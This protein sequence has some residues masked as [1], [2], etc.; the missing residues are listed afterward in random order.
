MSS[1]CSGELHTTAKKAS[2][3]LLIISGGPMESR[4]FAQ[5]CCG[6]QQS[7]ESPV[8]IRCCRQY[9]ECPGGCLEFILLATHTL[10]PWASAAPPQSWESSSARLLSAFHTACSPIRVSPILHSL[11][12]FWCSS[13]FKLKSYFFGFLSVCLLFCVLASLFSVWDLSSPTRDQIHSSCFGS[14]ES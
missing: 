3:P 1:R 11:G 4:S 6:E 5:P 12:T 7:H 14:V 13:I 2:S 8:T 9:R 10:Q